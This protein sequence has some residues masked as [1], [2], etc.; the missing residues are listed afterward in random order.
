MWN[1]RRVPNATMVPF[2]QLYG[3][4]DYIAHPFAILGSAVKV[5]VM[6]SKRRS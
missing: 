4:H 2:E 6:P 3:K 1:R 5:H